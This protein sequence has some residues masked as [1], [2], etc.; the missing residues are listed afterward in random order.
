MIVIIGTSNYFISFIILVG[1]H[2]DLGDAQL[3][4]VDREVAGVVKASY[5]DDE[6]AGLDNGEVT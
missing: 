6:V 1:V 3:G 5:Y 4:H 2:L